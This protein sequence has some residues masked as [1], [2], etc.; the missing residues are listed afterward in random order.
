MSTRCLRAAPVLLA[1]SLTGCVTTVSR[2][3]TPAAAP[4]PRPVRD[5]AVGSF[6]TTFWCGPPLDLFDD[7]RAAEIAAAGFTVVGPP[8]EGEFSADRARRALEIAARHGLDMWIEDPRFGAAARRN[9]DWE[10]A[11]ASATEAYRDQPGFGGYF[12]TDEPNPDQFPD[13]AAIV[14]RLRESDPAHLAYINL[15]PE[16][17]VH[18]PGAPSY[19][20]YL[21]RF[22]TTVHPRLLSYDY[23]PFGVGQDRRT[24]FSSLDLVR[25]LAA[26]HD[27][28]FML[29]VLT[30]PHGPYRDPTEPELRW[31]VLHALAYG[32]RGVSYFAYWTPENVGDAASMNFRHGVIEA[33]RAT[34]HYDEV[35]RLNRLARGIAREL[36]GFRSVSVADSRGEVASPL[37]LGPIDAIEHASVTV[38]LFAEDSGRLAALLVNRDY[39][40][41]V[42]ASLRLRA[43]A[44]PPQRFDVDTGVWQDRN[45]TDIR[46]AAGG[47]ELIRWTR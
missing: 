6:I 39:R 3:S 10:A 26:Q 43:G 4:R 7:S 8:C 33:G 17:A 31:Q 38:G 40:Q 15:L 47:A 45:D 9:P 42:T 44:L 14:E 18:G 21:E 37:P 27:L 28:P 20:E 36:E 11:L 13:L 1:L 19:Q 25:S 16:Y 41:S 32:A 12:V 5:T 22:I 35:A 24:F 30:M 34:R 46:L 29:I 23:Y 2:I